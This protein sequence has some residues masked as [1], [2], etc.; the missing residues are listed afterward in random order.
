MNDT[1]RILSLDVI[2]GIAVMGIFSVNVIAFAMPLQAYFNPAAYGGT[3]GA[4]LLVW[5]FNFVLIDGKMRGLFTLLFGASTLLVVERA[6]AAGRSAAATHYRRM[7]WL[8]LFGAIHYYLIWSGDILT[9]YAIVGLVAFL[10][11]DAPV[12]L[13][14]ALGLAFI[15]FDVLMMAGLAAAIS[16]AQAD[17]ALHGPNGA[18]A[19]QMRGIADF[20]MPLQPDALARNLALYRGP[21]PAIL[22]DR[23][24]EGADGPLS[25]L[26]VSG[27]ETLGSILL[28][29]AG[30]KSGFLT[31]SWSRARYRWIAAV[32][33]GAGTVAYAILGWRIW[34]SG[35]AASTIAWNFLVLSAPFRLMM[36]FGYAAAIVLLARRHGPIAR[37]IAAV[38]RA[39]FTNY[40]GTSLVAVFIFQGLGLYGHLDRATAWLF[41]P[42][43]WLVML[44]W[45]K[46]WLDRY[47]YGPFEYAWRSLA[48]WSL[49]PMLRREGSAAGAAEA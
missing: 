21:Y 14:V 39:A 43:F 41:A 34:S 31:G 27:P 30:L 22:H 42:A 10:L 18:I 29:M 32:G 4:A 33:L 15:L 9:L 3:H 19:S 24:T 36:M 16:A 44:L 8:L 5:A 2:R 37:R 7:G 6:E 47:R 20:L 1:D 12:R 13:L 38:G 26:W 25:Q 46:P 48:R 11:R 17:L 35:F 45:S 40:L 23:L 28:G 49:Q